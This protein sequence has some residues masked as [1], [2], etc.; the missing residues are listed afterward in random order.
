MEP[1]QSTGPSCRV[2][3]VFARGLVPYVSSTQDGFSRRTKVI[4]A[5]TRA[6]IVIQW[7]IHCVTKTQLPAFQIEL[8]TLFSMVPLLFS[9]QDHVAVD[10]A[11][12]S[13]SSTLMYWDISPNFTVGRW[14]VSA[15]SLGIRRLRWRPPESLR[16]FEA[17]LFLRSLP[18]W[19]MSQSSS[20]TFKIMQYYIKIAKEVAREII[21]KQP[22]HY[23][24][25]K[26][27]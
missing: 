22:E 2:D 25:G 8:L 4:G 17:F 23:L 10:C 14:M 7:C 9:F 11:L 18:R 6:C 26:E 13:K 27:G 15:A 21:D 3:D 16:V 5:M 1:V 19:L 12:A 20:R 24:G